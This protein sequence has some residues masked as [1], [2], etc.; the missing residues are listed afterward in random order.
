MSTV[1]EPARTEQKQV[2]EGVVRG[3][4]IELSAAPIF[5]DGQR[6]AV[7]LQ[8]L[9]NHET[10][11]KCS[12]DVLRFAMEQHVGEFLPKVLEMTRQTFPSARR[13]AIVV[14]EDTEIP[15][16]HHIVF[17]VEASGLSV[18]QAVE[19]DWRWCRDIFDVCPSTH[20]CVFRLSL[21]LV[22]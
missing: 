6:V 17:E 11:A 18:D 7:E 2:L 1:I 10:G 4:S 8:K 22:E 20:V 9:S 21:R 3:Q 14:D 13:L 16:D 5:P 12:D 15:N 19:A